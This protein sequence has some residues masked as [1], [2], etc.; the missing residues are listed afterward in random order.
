[1]TGISCELVQNL[2][3][4]KCLVES[5]NRN[6]REDNWKKKRHYN[7]SFWHVK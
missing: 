6:R 3:Y 2:K 1:M 4:Y 5:S 7:E